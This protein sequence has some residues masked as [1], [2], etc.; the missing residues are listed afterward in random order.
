MNRRT[1][2]LWDEASKSWLPTSVPEEIA[3]LLE[4][5]GVVYEKLCA[6]IGGIPDCE[7]PSGGDYM[8][9]RNY[10][11]AFILDAFHRGRKAGTPVESSQPAKS[12]AALACCL[13]QIATLE[14]ELPEMAKRGALELRAKILNDPLKYPKMY[15]SMFPSLWDCLNVWRVSLMCKITRNPEYGR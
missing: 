11:F 4:P 8:E 12:E 6:W 13:T 1:I 3:D 7:V 2:L 15:R 10:V 14:T 5:C 9:M